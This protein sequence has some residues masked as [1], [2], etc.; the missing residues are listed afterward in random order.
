MTEPFAAPAKAETDAI[1]V[2]AKAMA[3][4]ALA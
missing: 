1:P 4:E 2:I 3:A